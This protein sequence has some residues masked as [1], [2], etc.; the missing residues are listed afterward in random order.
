MKISLDPRKNRARLEAREAERHPERYGPDG[1][2]G[3]AE[4]RRAGFVENCRRQADEAA[5]AERTVLS[6][7]I[8]GARGAIGQIIEAVEAGGWLL[9]GQTDATYNSIL[10]FRRVAYTACTTGASN[11]E[12]NIRLG[13]A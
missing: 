9:V 7:R 1:R 6:L 8:Q 12:T 13:R 3:F 10:T 2:L 5:Q 4:V 11:A